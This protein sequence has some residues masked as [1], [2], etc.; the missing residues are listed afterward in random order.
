MLATHKA[1]NMAAAGNWMPI[2]PLQFAPH[3]INER[4]VE[5]GFC[6]PI[7]SA[8]AA[9]FYKAWTGVEQSIK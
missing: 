5:I 6:R 1:I 3:I 4:N 9:E 8:L 7:R 2:N